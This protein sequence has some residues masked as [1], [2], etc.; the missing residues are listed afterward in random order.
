MADNPKKK[1]QDA[2]LVA[3]EQAYEVAYFRKKHSISTEQARKIIDQAGP[4][5]DKANSLAEKV[6]K[7]LKA[8]GLI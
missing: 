1:K 7:Q 4:S 8:K 6:K 5:R 3:G 2:K